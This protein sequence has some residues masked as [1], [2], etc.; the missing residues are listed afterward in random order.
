LVGAVRQEDMV[1]RLGGDEFVIALWEIGQADEGVTKL[2]EKVIEAVS[3][4]YRINSRDVSITA[5][6]GVGIYPTHGD[7]VVALMKS[8]D[9]ALIEAKRTGKNDFRIA[10]RSDLI[11]IT[12]LK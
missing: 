11:G 4:P 8:A 6:V 1:A 12:R 10:A 2:V 7:E 9:Q 5:S 3:Q